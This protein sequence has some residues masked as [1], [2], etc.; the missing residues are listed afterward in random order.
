MIH[1]C[2]TNTKE[3]FAFWESDSPPSEICMLKI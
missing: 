1:I 2:E 3:D